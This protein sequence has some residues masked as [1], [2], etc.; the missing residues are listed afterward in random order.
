MGPAR[1][2]ARQRRADVT[3][4][5]WLTSE[6]PQR[7]YSFARQVAVPVLKAGR[8]RLRLFACACCRQAWHLL[9]DAGRAAV[10]AAEGYADGRIAPSQLREA[11][12]AAWST[13]GAGRLVRESARGA[14]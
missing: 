11:H 4:Q 14:A 5:E 8:R 9:G 1:S 10:E 6:S 2:S 3:E 12:G 7:L 13:T